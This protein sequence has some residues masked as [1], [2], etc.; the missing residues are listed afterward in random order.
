MSLI[1]ETNFMKD[2]QITDLIRSLTAL[3]TVFF[4]GIISLGTTTFA[5]GGGG[6]AGGIYKSRP[7]E[8]TQQN[9]NCIGATGIKARIYRGLVVKVEGLTENCPADGKIKVGQIITGVNGKSFEGNN[10]YVVLGNAL[11]GAEATDGKMVF[12]VKDSEKTPSRKVTVLIPVL[13]SYS[14][15]WPLNCEK[16]N[17]IIKQAAE[18]YSTNKEF[19]KKYLKSRGIG[20]ALGCLFLLST[21]EDKYLPVVKEYFAKFPKNVSSI[22]GHTWNNGYNGIACGEYYLRTGDKSVLPILQYYCDD[23]QKRQKFGRGW[24]HWGDGI[25]PGYVA[26]GLMNPAGA[27]ILTTLLLGKECGVNVDQDTLIGSLRYWY[28]FAGHGTVPYGDHRAEGGLG[29]NGKDGMAAAIMQI[30]SGAQGNTEIYEMAKKYLSMS[31]VTSYPVMVRGHGDDGRGDGIW[32]GIASAYMLDFD[33]KQYHEAMNRLQWWYDLSRRPSG[34]IGMAT[35]ASFDDEGSGAAVAL[36]YTA[37]L[38]KL[39]ITGASRSKYAKSFTLPETL[40]GTKADLAF[41]SAENNP[42]YS[43]YGKNEPTHVPFYKF[44]GAYHKPH[45]L[46]TVPRKEML[47]NVYHRRYMIRAQAAKALRA[48]GAFDELEK[49]LVDSDPRMRR[50]GLDGMMDYTYW[51]GAGKNPIKADQFSP[52]MLASIKKMLADP[53]ESLWVVDGALAVL[54]FAPAKDIAACKS[55]IMPWTTHRDWWLRESAFMALS[56]LDKEDALYQE[57]VPTLLKMMAAEYHTM[58]RDRMLSSITKSLRK[59]N[60]DSPVGKA[61]LGGML[62]AA[63]EST[64]LAG[65][66]S[67]EGA[68][69]VFK[70]AVE[71]AKYPETAVTIGRIIEKRAGVLGVD[72]VAAVGKEL[73]KHLDKVSSKDRKVLTEIIY[74]YRDGMIKEMKAGTMNPNLMDTLIEF[75][76]LKNP[77]IGWQRIGTPTSENRVWSYTTVKPVGKDILHPSEGKRHRQIT[78]P[79]ELKDWYKPDFDDSK[80]NKGKAPIGV[81]VFTKK[82][83]K[84]FIENKSKWGDGEY[85][86]MRTTFELDSTDFDKYRLRA[87]AKMGFTIYVNGQRI[88]N[89]VWFEFSPFYKKYEISGG[90]NKVFRKGTNTLAIYAGIGFDQ[91]NFKPI[92][93]IDLYI[94]GFDTSDLK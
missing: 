34:A 15:T 19:K 67:G 16:S 27:Q 37:P 50:A 77:N 79:E 29:S 58:P 10:L 66:R 21:G 20:G 78:L 68:H 31:M 84:T 38:K 87:L 48:T 74:G 93:Q 75:T 59:Y 39:R 40:W 54:K 44:G 82:R 72:K 52:K 30:A 81:G 36:S 76:K 14:K 64:I 47:K 17:R 49:L 26:S 35:I 73:L 42:K 53:K 60:A 46:N 80:W 69:N 33:A 2:K 85:I 71:C 63:R 7:S 24:T 62:K 12:D 55:K 5:G 92:G 51:F 23:A 65:E 9:I 22:G 4:I 25:S 43:L 41:L 86:L 18:Y 90:H 45:D 70:V 83:S 89:Y 94:E 88:F 91:E 61:S 13:G 32:R 8:K 6:N 56:G 1:E 3:F 28:R 11:T 57:A